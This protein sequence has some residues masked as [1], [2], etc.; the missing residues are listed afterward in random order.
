[1]SRVDEEGEE[2]DELVT[3]NDLDDEE[4][5]QDAFGVSYVDDCPCEE[6]YDE[7]IGDE[8][9]IIYTGTNISAVPTYVDIAGGSVISLTGTSLSN[10]SICRV[11]TDVTA[12]VRFVSCVDPMRNFSAQ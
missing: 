7:V 4:E 3:C 10:S 2:Y 6:Y 1:M 5:L 11:G 9:T 12:P 8:T